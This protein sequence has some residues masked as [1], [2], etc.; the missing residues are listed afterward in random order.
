MTAPA[1]PHHIMATTAESHHI[2]ATTAEPHHVMASTPEP[3]HVM[4]AMAEPHHVM[5]SSHQ[6]SPGD[7]LEGGYSNQAPANRWTRL[8][9]SVMDPQLGL[10]RVLS[11]SSPVVLNP[12]L[13]ALEVIPLSAVLPVVAPAILCLGH[14]HLRCSSRG[15]GGDH[16]SSSRG[17]CGNCSAT[18]PSINRVC[19]KSRPHALSHP[20]RSSMPAMSHLK[21]T[22]IPAMSLS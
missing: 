12:S 20:M 4:T 14:T 9:T 13:V 21:S 3:H 17:G 16:Y 6:V 22:S 2:M 5:V 11:R 19:P 1:E 15:D 10:V 18:R 7:F 8:T